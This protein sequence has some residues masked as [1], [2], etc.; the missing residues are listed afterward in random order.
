MC[1]N[2]T[3][4]MCAAS[5]ASE[6]TQHGMCWAHSSATHPRC[7]PLPPLLPS[8]ALG[9]HCASPR[10]EDMFA[11]MYGDSKMNGGMFSK[12]MSVANRSVRKI[13]GVRRISEGKLSDQGLSHI[14]QAVSCAKA[15]TFP[16]PCSRETFA[17]FAH[18]SQSAS[19]WVTH[20]INP[21]A[22]WHI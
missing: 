10:F 4:D 15:H 12:M 13:S 3:D 2:G 14:L 17:H 18:R 6:Q 1:R 8:R 11:D 16:F 5:C 20:A 19:L 9:P 7:G 22:S 21:D